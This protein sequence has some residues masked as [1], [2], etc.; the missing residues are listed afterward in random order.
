MN[1]KPV[2]MFDSG[3][4]GLT[5][6]RAF[7]DRMPFEHL[8]Y[9]GDDARGPYGPR[10]I[11]E[12]RKFAG[13]II[14]Y[15]LGFGVKLVVIACNSA[16]AA[17]LEEA[18]AYYSIPVVGVIKP[19]VRAALR[20]TKSKRIGVIGTEC[21]IKSGSYERALRRLDPRSDIVS[22]AC[23]ALVEFVERGEVE[24]EEIERVAVKCL[25]PVVNE[26][27]DTLILGCTHYPLLSDLIQRIVGLD[28][29]LVNSAQET[30]TEVEDILERLGWK[31]NS[32]E[33]GIHH[34]LTTG[35][36]EKSRKLGRVFLGPEVENVMSIP[37][38]FSYRPP[39]EFT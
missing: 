6:A 26:G 17:A 20:H 32:G 38:D 24:G 15:L 36:A 5:V 29:K 30:A 10:S 7:I 25:M 14:D 1:E 23:P 11:D 16:T 4:G 2:G 34:F 39:L 28:I 22:R 35:D 27:I 8:I 21:T 12:V 33:K 31:R 37:E 18:Q 9:I 3:V 19:G 13:D